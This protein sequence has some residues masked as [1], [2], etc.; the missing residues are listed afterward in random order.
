MPGV[1]FFGAALGGMRAAIRCSARLRST[2]CR[3]AIERTGCAWKVQ[4]PACEAM[5]GVPGRAASSCFKALNI[6]DICCGGRARFRGNHAYLFDLKYIYGRE[7]QSISRPEA[8]DRVWISSSWPGSPHCPPEL[9]T[10]CLQRRPPCESHLPRPGSPG[11]V[12]RMLSRRA[13]SRART[14]DRPAC[15]STVSLSITCAASR[16]PSCVP[17]PG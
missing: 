10:A 16:R 15:A 8:E 4:I 6:L 12:S 1:S 14:R 11:T 7:T 2:S 5:P 3:R 17:P 9:S 13:D